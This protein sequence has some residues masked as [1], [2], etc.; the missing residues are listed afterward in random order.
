MRGVRIG[1][2]G[3]LKVIVDGRDVAISGTRL[4]VLLAELAMAAPSPVNAS[5]LALRLWAEDVPAEMGNAL[6]SLVSRL[7]RALGDPALVSQSAA[8][9]ALAV[10][11]P[12]VD[13][14]EFSRL[15]RKASSE[16]TAADVDGAAQSARQALALWRGDPP[17]DLGLSLSELY[18]STRGVLIEAR[19]R[20]GES[21]ELIAELDE[22]IG[23]N[24]LRE[25]FVEQRMRALAMAGRQPEALASYE[26]LRS[27]LTEEL[28]VDPSARLQDLHL[29]LLRGELDPRPVRADT[30][31]AALTS[32]IGR[33]GEVSQIA[34][35]LD[36]ARLITLLGP[37][38]AGK[39]RLAIETV[40]SVSE[41]GS[42]GYGVWLVELAPVIN[43]A[44]VAQAVYD[45]LGVRAAALLDRSGRPAGDVIDRIVDVLLDRPTILIVDNCEHLLGAAAQ[46]CATL[47]ARCPLLRIVAT[48]R[49]PLGVLGETLLPVAPLA[50][51]PGIA[52]FTDR[53]G[54][55]RPGFR[56]EHDASGQHEAAAVAEIVRRLDGLP[57]AIELAAAR[58]RTM[59]AAQI[60]ARLS[61]RFALL[62]TG[63]RAA[64]PRQQSLRAVVQ[65]SWELLTDDERTMAEDL[66]V[67]SGLISID[68][69]AAVV[70][71]VHTEA[72]LSLLVDKSLLQQVNLQY[73]M[74]ETIREYGL[75]QLAARGALDAVRLAHAQY[76]AD[77]VHTAAPRI[78]AA[79]QLEWMARLDAEQPD[80]L[81]ALTFLAAT[82]RAQAALELVTDLGWHWLVMGRHAEASTWLQI[83]LDAQGASH[84]E[85]RL[86]AECFYALNSFALGPNA[87]DTARV[88]DTADL[89]ARLAEVDA[90]QLPVLVLLRPMLTMFADG[91]MN[92][93][94]SPQLAGLFEDA[95]ASPDEWVSATARSFRAAVAENNG[96]LV[97]MR[98]DTELSLAQ[99]R[100]LG[101]RWGQANSLQVLGQL[102][103]MEGNLA[104]A[105]QDYLQALT[106]ATE[107]GAHEDQ[108][109]MR[110]RLI[111]VF[112]RQG[113]T[114]EARDQ[115]A[116]I[117]QMLADKPGG[118]MEVM[119]IQ[120]IRAEMAFT[121]GRIDE[122][123]RL[124]HEY[125]DRI[126]SLPQTVR[127]RAHAIALCL[128]LVAKIA[129][130]DSELGNA[131]AFLAK[132]YEAGLA[133]RDMPILASVGVMIARL[134][135]DVGAFRSAATILGA[136][137]QLRGSGDETS[138]EITAITNRLRA[139]L[140]SFDVDY[141]TGRALSRPEAIQ[142][143]DPGRL[144]ESQA[145]RR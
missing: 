20:A 108:M 100:A 98:R 72:L 125:F 145:R 105:E 93:E 9:Y 26:Q 11:R 102:D 130:G 52:L 32:F 119:F 104:A 37:G 121:D 114:R 85:S 43:P 31:P 14:Q 27:I 51:P 128:T 101:E 49:E 141:A 99:L 137:A 86:L 94:D 12:D 126:V 113:K 79:E 123:K 133:S 57:L 1:L 61:D 29:A 116:V 136:S 16:L 13:A 124:Q 127:S 82:G 103:L 91:S 18:L 131:R 142:Q 81:A 48:S 56:L 2:L 106:L 144:D 62:T 132:A 134:A 80:I 92:S 21:S 83:A 53:A 87:P 88:I 8:G 22:L 19:L 10:T 60:A 25:S 46:L 68:S 139:E 95:I 59:T 36:T 138:L 54:L 39:T 45:R 143:L 35:L 84:S 129:L 65:W 42:I 109:L 5:A 67:F 115:F 70:A 96:D 41:I 47:L 78:R 77:L 76:F 7:R 15:A 118:L 23:A 120:I 4:R 110:L 74:L 135:L 75:A 64:E 73:R 6:Q 111:E 89:N 112:H 3:D 44:E 117:E 34:A 71:S 33:D 40:R 30:L 69:A 28:G 38:G 58:M 63:N 122:A 17:E 66:A 50:A 140:P 90:E 107:L 24:P 97:G 55:V